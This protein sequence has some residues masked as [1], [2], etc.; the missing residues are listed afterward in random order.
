MPRI[1]AF[2]EENLPESIA[3]QPGTAEHNTSP[4][5]VSRIKLEILEEILE[6]QAGGT[7]MYFMFQPVRFLCLINNALF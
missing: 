6:F 3:N 1:E 4:E 7:G 5:E 2:P